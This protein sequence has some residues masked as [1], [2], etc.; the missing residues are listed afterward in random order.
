[1]ARISETYGAAFPVSGFFESP[2]I[3]GQA[4]ILEELLV[5]EI[6]SMSDEEAVALL[7]EPDD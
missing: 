5:A 2:T 4:A 3:A 7:A 1:M 6:E